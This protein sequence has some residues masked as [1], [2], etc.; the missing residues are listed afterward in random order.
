MMFTLIYSCIILSLLTMGVTSKVPPNIRVSGNKLVDENGQE[1]RCHGVDI[2]G[3]YQLRGLRK[4][5]PILHQVM[6]I[7]AST[8]MVFRKES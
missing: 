6:N 2:Q 7:N 4:V 8:T 3:K 1:F 5:S